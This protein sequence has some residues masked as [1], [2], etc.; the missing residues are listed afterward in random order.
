MR[1][2]E[3]SHEDKRYRG[4]RERERGHATPRL[5]V[6]SADWTQSCLQVY[7]CQEAC[8]R[9]RKTEGKEGGRICGY[10]R[11]RV[12]GFTVYIERG[13]KRWNNNGD[14]ARSTQKESEHLICHINTVPSCTQNRIARG[15]VGLIF[16]VIAMSLTAIASVITGAQELS[17]IT[18]ILH[19]QISEL[20]SSWV[21][22]EIG[23]ECF[24][25]CLCVCVRERER[26][27]SVCHLLFYVY[28]VLAFGNSYKSIT[29]TNGV[30]G[31]TL[32]MEHSN[33]KTC[34]LSLNY[35]HI[36]VFTANNI[37]VLRL[38]TTNKHYLPFIRGEK[39]DL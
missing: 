19:F 9:E 39:N 35:S 33:K 1:G 7:P 21:F 25:D 10:G 34:R 15:E 18:L 20:V 38:F 27:S 23:M 36:L 8:K 3:R 24:W 11:A 17:D 37:I 5:S 13:K 12:E 4:E 6:E 14:R 28:L 22:L 2:G 26:E 16:L 29:G 31:T 30:P 32:G